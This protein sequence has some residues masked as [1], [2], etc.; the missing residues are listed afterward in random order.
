MIL[1]M[2]LIFCFMFS[3]AL[4][5]FGIFLDVILT[6]GEF[7]VYGFAVSFLAE[8]RGYDKTKWFFA[9]FFG[10]IFA[11]IV[12]GIFLKDKQISS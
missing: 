8:Q 12:I 5:G 3:T 7:A 11:L 9:G 2:I 1:S 10:G 4:Q 6:L